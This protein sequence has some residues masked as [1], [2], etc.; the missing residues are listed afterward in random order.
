MV[1]PGSANPRMVTLL[2]ESKSWSQADL[3]AA[4]DVTQGY[5]SKVE[6]GRVDLGGERLQAVAEALG[7]PAVVLTNHDPQQQPE[8]SC[9]FHRRRRSRMTA[10][11][12]K[13]VEAVSHLT[14][15]SVDALTAGMDLACDIERMDIDAYDGDP[16][17][18]AQ[19]L[20][21][22]WRVPVGPIED[23]HA[24]MDRAGVVV[25]I[26]EFDTV[27]QDAFSTWPAGKAPVMVVRA[28]MSADRE[29]FSIAH[30]LGHVLMHVLPGEDQE[31]QADAF[32]A[33]FLVPAAEIAPQLAGLTTRDFSRLMELKVQWKISIAALIQRAKTLE[34]ISDRQFREFRIKLSQLGWHTVEPVP[35]PHGRAR[36]LDSILAAHR[37]GDTIDAAG[38]GL[39][40]LTAE[41]LLGSGD[42]TTYQ[43]REVS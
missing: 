12:A 3:A 27:A 11:A 35:I 19:M 38:P 4:A 23:L 24:L 2:R 42:R 26:R 36:L 13:R 20:R 37:R 40:L 10:G 9:M 41:T 17:R 28:G 25:V 39:A 5:I 15:I 18:V 31:Q 8:V 43:Q 1:A 16:V 14:R 34:L 33:E 21:R 7:C 30:E 29:R 32:A 22:R 6:N